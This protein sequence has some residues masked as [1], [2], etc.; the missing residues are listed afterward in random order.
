IFAAPD[1]AQ[2]S[3]GVQQL[4]SRASSLV[5]DVVQQPQTHLSNGTEEEGLPAQASNGPVVDA[6]NSVMSPPTDKKKKKKT[7]KGASDESSMAEVNTTHRPNTRHHVTASTLRTSRHTRVAAGTAKA[8][9]SAQYKMKGSWR[10]VTA[11]TG[12]GIS[13]GGLKR[14]DTAGHGGRGNTSKRRR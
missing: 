14:K 8:L 7:R 5:A 11:D 13:S 6:S 4:P 1:C 12:N 3:D 2:P 9:V 10:G